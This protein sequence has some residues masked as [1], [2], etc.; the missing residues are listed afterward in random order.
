MHHCDQWRTVMTLLNDGEWKT[1]VDSV[2]A[3]KCHI[4]QS[5]VTRLKN[6]SLMQS[7]S[8]L[9]PAKTDSCRKFITKHGTQSVM[10]TKNIGKKRGAKGKNAISKKALSPVRGHSGP[11]PRMMQVN[12]ALDNP[13]AAAHG[14]ISHCPLEF[15]KSFAEKLLLLVNEKLQKQGE[16]A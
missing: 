2:V 6:S 5:M 11:G 8:E 7:I 9:T 4:D 12:L 15:V 16:Q 3:R 14:V 10:N 13:D 1:W